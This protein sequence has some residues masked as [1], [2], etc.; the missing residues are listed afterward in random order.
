MKIS[1]L[2]P[3]LGRPNAIL[4]LLRSSAAA[5]A[6]GAASIIFILDREDP[7]THKEI[8]AAHRAGWQ[9][10]TVFEDGT[11]PH[12]V[13][14]GVVAS[15]EPLVLPTAD[16]VV[17]HPLWLEH[18]LAAFQPGIDVV[19]TNDLTPIT[20]DGTHATMPIVR[21]SYIEQPGAAFAE[22]G[23][24]FHEGYHHNRCETETCQLA[25]HRGVWRFCAESIIEHRH[26]SWGSREIDETDRK[27]N[28]QNRQADEALFVER[29]AAWRQ[30]A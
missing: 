13:N 7:E 23:A 3:T 30:S 10:G 15:S 29:E 11:Y 18:A 5:T 2:V 8:A 14:A 26:H 6:P 12:K 24:L 27:G 17:F 28:L 25:M 9:F 20:A 22:P 16:D 4:P 1:I 21:R 19:G